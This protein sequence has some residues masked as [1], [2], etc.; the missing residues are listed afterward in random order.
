[1][2]ASLSIIEPVS[3]TLK[4]EPL[5]GAASV[6]AVIQLT[7]AIAK[8]CGSYIGQV[9]EAKKD[10]LHLQ[11][12]VNALS[13]VL[14]SLEKLLQELS[15]EKLATSQDLVDNITKCSLGLAI[16]KEKIDPEIAQRRMRKW[17]F[18]AFKWPLKREQV[19]KAISEI[20]RYKTLFDLSFQIEQMRYTNRLNQKI[21]LGRLHVAKGAAYNDYENQHEECLEGTRVELLHSI[22]NWTKAPDGKC[23]FWLC[24]MA[25]TGK[26]TVS[27]T[28]ASRLKGQ[29]LLAASFFF[30]RGE[31]DRGNAKMLFSTLAKQLGGTMPQLSPSIQKAIEDDPDISG[32]ALR[33]QFEKLILQPLLAIDQDPITTMV[34]IIDALDECDKEDDV[35]TILRLLPQLQRSSFVQLRFLLTSRPELPI[36]LGFMGMAGGYQDLILHKIPEPVIKHDIKL[37]LEEKFVQLKQ[38]RLISSDWPGDAIISKLVDRATPLFISATTLYK[39]ISDKRRNPEARLRAIL[40][41]ETNY[42]SRMDS[43]YLPVLNQ[44][45]TDQDEQ[46]TQ[47]LVKEFKDIVGVIILLVTPLS[48][49]SLARL[50]DMELINI[51]THL[52]LFHSVVDVPAELDEPVRILHLSFRDFLLDDTN[53]EN[54]FWINEKEVH[55]KLMSQCLK[56]MRHKEYGLKKDICN[57]QH[58][59]IQ[60]GEIYRYTIDHCL[61]PELHYACR[62]WAHHLLQS[63]NP[64]NKLIHAFSFLRVHLLHWIE[65]MSL[66][67]IISEAVGV[68]HGLQSVIKVSIKFL[69]HLEILK[70][71][72][73]SKFGN[74]SVSS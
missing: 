38:E 63:H 61:P 67:G 59:G 6:I 49:N 41:D 65:A 11:E 2:H 1:M 33:E 3:R 8:I 69:I 53:K 43:T 37:Y 30:K 44:L 50:S 55:Q 72:G 64:A 13:Q 5:S 58:P 10:I 21:D 22:N 60:R 48:V 35:W 68:I 29:N 9:K 19:V 74:I 54:P 25:G 27:R 36:R 46:D 7:G 73:R 16:L 57:L 40:S 52:D 56:V 23:I 71:I 12:E 18:R 66:L 51:Q 62:Y 17:G 42:A 20:E 45:L 4:M 26:S 32:R 15:E 14:K 34:I 31:Q 47:Q 39:F 70:D 24:G 28:V